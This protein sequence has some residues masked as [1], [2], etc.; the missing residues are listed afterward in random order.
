MDFSQSAYLM[1]SLR[2][3]Y[4]DELCTSCQSFVGIPAQFE[5]IVTWAGFIK[6]GLK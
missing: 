1:G 2:H 6:H 3:E 4:F 5:P